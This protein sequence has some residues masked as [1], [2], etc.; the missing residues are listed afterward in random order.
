MK[1]TPALMIVGGLM[2]FWTSVFVAVLL[3]ALTMQEAPNQ[4]NIWRGAATPEESWT[5]DERAG[6][7]LYVSNGCSYCHSMYYRTIDWE[8]GLDRMSERSDYVG[9]E[10]IILGT[11]RTG[12][13]LSQEGGLHPDDWQKA[14]FANPRNTRPESLMPSWE[15][16][17]QDDIRQLTRF[18]QSAGLKNADARVKRQDEWKAL[19]VKA[20]YS[21]PNGT[22]DVD[23]NVEWLHSWVPQV[24]REMP[25]PYPATTAE[26]LRGETIYQGYCIN[27]HGPVGDGAGTAKPFLA[28]PPLNFTVLKRHLVN[29]KYIGGIFYYQVMNGITGTAM[30]FFKTELESE[31]IWAVSNY[32]ASKFVDYSDSTLEPRGIPAANE[33]PWTNP[34]QPPPASL[35]YSASQPATREARP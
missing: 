17:G 6:H 2:V 8:F 19:A 20:Y 3:P 1:M 21:G 31:K 7:K 24:W 25:N 28:P 22:A 12:P 34:Y 33:P 13:D 26:L 32:L 29:N 4:G 10:P 23:K 5:A 30:P 27:C 15:F 14:H 9:M 35:V 16:L 18:V 11:E